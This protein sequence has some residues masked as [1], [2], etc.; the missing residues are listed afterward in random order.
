MQ[1]MKKVAIIIAFKDF[2]DEEYFFSKQV[3][4]SNGIKTETFSNEKGLAIGK[5]GGEA[6]AKSLDDL[7]ISDY[8]AIIFVG[9]NGAIIF[10]DNE[11][12]YNLIKKAQNENKIIA[13]I[14]IA[15]IILAKAGALRNKK[16]VVWSSLIDKSGIEIIKKNQG[17]Y[18]E[19]PVVVDGN[20][21]TG[22]NHE[23]AKIFGQTIVD[24]LKK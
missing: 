18:E 20:I 21:I 7:N 3:L 12:S 13:A 8:E 5:F 4:E 9:G 19:K 22:Q 17:I 23:A 6:I 15:P 16:A 14:C 24:F 2:R 1:V 11:K 10:L